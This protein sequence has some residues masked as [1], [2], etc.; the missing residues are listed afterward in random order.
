MKQRWWTPNLVLI[1][2]LLS[3]LCSGIAVARE[4]D[5]TL[6]CQPDSGFWKQENGIDILSGAICTRDQEEGL[7]RITFNAEQTNHAFSPTITAKAGTLR[8]LASVGDTLFYAD[9]EH[10]Y[11]VDNNSFKVE[12]TRP[13]SKAVM[14][15]KPVQERFAAFMVSVPDE[16]G[17][18]VDTLKI[19][20]VDHG[21][22]I[23]R[24]SSPINMAEH[25]EFVWQAD[26]LIN[27]EHHHLTWWPRAGTTFESPVTIDLSQPLPSSAEYQLDDTGML[28]IH[29]EKNRIHYYRFDTK[30]RVSAHLNATASVRG[31]GGSTTRAMGVTS[32]L[33][34]VRVVARMNNVLQNRYE[35]KYWRVK[36]DSPMIL[37]DGETLVLDGGEDNRSQSIDTSAMTWKRMALMDYS[38]PGK[39][40]LLK[41]NILTTRHESGSSALIRWDVT[42]GN[43]IAKLPFSA[44]EPLGNETDFSRIERITP[45]PTHD[46][47]LIL[48]LNRLTDNQ[49]ELTFVILDLKTMKLVP[50]GKVFYANARVL[51]LPNTI[52]LHEGGFAISD[53]THGLEWYIFGDGVRKQSLTDIPTT[54]ASEQLTPA[55]KWYGY[56]YDEGQCIIPAEVSTTT[57]EDSS[58]SRTKAWEPQITLS[59]D[60]QPPLSAKLVAVFALLAM[61]MITIWRNGIFAKSMLRP[62]DTNKDDPYVQYSSTTFEILDEKN[63]RF[64]TERDRTSFLTPNFLSQTWFR[65]LFSIA[66]G[67]GAAAFTALRFFSD[68][69]PSVFFAWLVI[70]AV[71]VTAAV[72]VIISWSF[73]NRQYLFRFGRFVEGTWINCAKRNQSIVYTA[74]NH[75]TYEISRYQWKRVDFVPI[76]LYDPN[77]PAYSVQYTGS[78][79]YALGE[80]L[81]R[82]AKTL[83]ACCIDIVRLA[84]V[85]LILAICITSTQHFFKNT[86]PNPLS[87]KELNA[88][89]SDPQTFLTSCLDACQEDMCFKQ[90]QNRQMLLVYEDAG[91][92]LGSDPDMMPETFL[93]NAHETLTK[94][95]AILEDTASSCHEKATQLLSV[96]IMPENLSHAFWNVYGQKEVYDL[97][98]IEA[99]HQS[100]LKDI[101]YFQALC[102]E[103]GQCARDAQSCPPPP[104]CAGSAIQLKQHV[105]DFARELKI[106]A[107]EE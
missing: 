83:R 49:R 74:E 25:I 32:D 85:T 50:E 65:L 12:W 24:L 45:I 52:K 64:V 56:C 6:V 18:P 77:R 78:V 19:L 34:I 81:D 21:H 91:Y 99:Q 1:F 89:S 86:Y 102:D 107:I 84:V 22:V 44:F 61:L 14:L 28:V 23:E 13:W 58:A 101:A 104:Q 88:L 92:E 100:L 11:A 37:A 4:P 38:A 40:A 43:P 29:R 46:G 93:A 106:P 71:P 94:A 79:A 31:I 70:L 55:E 20:T 2:S 76:V 17:T 63:R 15:Q 33:N 10:L 54:Y 73:W 69:T 82:D 30:A 16:Q 35:A 66:A 48:E 60:H 103:A 72:W 59:H 53:Q 26:R 67:I 39:L 95:T 27:V 57:E 90:C 97:S 96:D 51:D 36:D 5:P 98:K 47:Y 105:C 8:S 41:D 7:Y 87:I 9:D 3:C 75:K 80:K 62:N 68:D 42:T